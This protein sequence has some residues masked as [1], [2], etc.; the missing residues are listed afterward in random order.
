[1][2]NRWQQSNFIASTTYSILRAKDRKSQIFAEIHE[3]LINP[4]EKCKTKGS[5]LSFLQVF[6]WSF[7]FFIAENTTEVYAKAAMPKNY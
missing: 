4:M 6:S 5:T 3:F 2:S 1:M 7:I